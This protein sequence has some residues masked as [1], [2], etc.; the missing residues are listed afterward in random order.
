M[1]ATTDSR[2]SSAGEHID[3]RFEARRDEVRRVRNARRR[4]IAFA[5]ASVVIAVGLG[6]LAVGSPLLDVDRVLV[7]GAQRADAEEIEAAAAVELGDRMV[8][9]DV[10]AVSERVERLAWVEEASVSRRWPGTVH[11]AVTEAR[12]AAYAMVGGQVALVGS[13]G[14]VL[15]VVPAAELPA[16]LVEIRGVR[17]LP[18]PGEQ[19]YPLGVAGV[20]RELPT[21]LAQQVEAVDLGRVDDVVLVLRAAPEIRLGNLED[22]SYK[23]AV[24]LA[25][26]ERLGEET[27]DVSYVDV[28]VP[29]RPIAGTTGGELGELPSLD[30]PARP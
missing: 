30:A 4:R 24:A 23:G 12:A 16:G 6:V 27:A 11:I 19:L 14:R 17:V 20:T 8:T 10:G 15:A 22:V 7:E 1:T 26:L 25:V 13:R 21:E 3:P 9:L 5:V 2:V 18:E 28:A 29:S